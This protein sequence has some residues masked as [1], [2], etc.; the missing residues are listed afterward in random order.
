MTRTRPL[1]RGEV[2]LLR[3][4]VTPFDVQRM[5]WPS[6][7]DPADC[8]RW[9]AEVWAEPDF[10]TAVRA[11]TPRLVRAVEQAVDDPTRAPTKIRRAVTA[12]ARYLLR[13]TGRPTPFGLFAGMATA[14]CGPA[15]VRFG[16][17]HRPVAR[18][19]TL[20]LD[21][22]RRDLQSRS[23]VLPHLIVAADDLTV[24]RGSTLERPLPGGR[25]AT[26]RLTRP[27]AA[28]L[29]MAA[30]PVPYR[31]VVERLITMGGSAAQAAHLLATAVG[32]GL[33]T[34]QLQAP[35]TDMDPLGHL[36]HVL[37]PVT[38]QLEPETVDV[39]RELRDVHRLLGRHNTAWDQSTAREIRDQAERRM[40]AINDAGRVRLSVD[41]RLDATVQIPAPVLDE[42]EAAAH[43]LLRLTR[44]QGERPAWAAYHSVFW[45]RYGAGSLVPV[46]DAVDL[47]AGVGLPAGFATSL[48]PEPPTKALPR[49]EL[50]MRRAWQAAV[51][52]E[53]EI[54]L[55]DADIEEL[56]PTSHGGA[57]EAAIAPHVEM[58]VRVYAESQQDL[59]RGDFTVSVRPAW[60]TG[61]L[62][63]RF[64]AILRDGGLR[65]AYGKL[66]TLVDGALPAQLSFTPLYPH[67][68][69]V[70][71]TPAF[72]P[73]VIPLGEHRPPS[74][75]F[76]P[77]D[78]LAVLSTGKRL[79][80]VSLSRRRV[81]EP[82]VLH[83]LA[84]EKQAPPLVR[85]LAQLGRGF[86]TA[87]T[88]F[89]WGPLAA[90]MPFL[91]R[92]RYRKSLLTPA[93]WRL[94]ASDLPAGSFDRAWHE[95]LTDWAHAWRCPR[96]V[97]L[98]EGD[99]TL[100]LDL[101]V[102][103]HARLLFDHLRRHE[104]ADLY[105]AAGEENLGWIG[106]AHEIV[107][108]LTSTRPPLP[109]PN[110]Q[111]APVVTNRT[112]SDPGSDRPW[113]QAKL[114]T[115]PAAMDQILARALP[116]SLEQLDIW[117]VRYRSL[118]EE[119]HLRLRI[120]APDP[121]AH[122]TITQTIVSWARQLQDDALAS[123]LVFDGYRPETGRYGTGAAMSAAEEVFTADSS[124]VR[125]ALADLPR[126]DRRLLCVLGMV[127]IALGLLGEDDGT[128]WM[129]TNPAPGIGLPSVTRAV[130]QQTRAGLQTRPSGWT[131]RLDAAS[132]ARRNALHR[133][134]KHLADG[135]ITTVLESL[136]HMHHNRCIGPDRESEAACRHA[137]RQACRTVWI[138]RAD[139]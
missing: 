55:S 86:A 110:I 98:R 126:T 73:Y 64:A 78:D 39:L 3:A 101:R 109:A 18:P 115:A 95:A 127:D 13:A 105:E 29:E 7:D 108:P 32:A 122:A 37:E 106:H 88:Q 90:G 136:L 66:P 51:T 112:L 111:D 124:A 82:V 84:L 60:S 87:W 139:Q 123:R 92:V 132:T 58:G 30:V 79:H 33:V 62:T 80:L 61:N 47:A 93:R 74:A 54:R 45:D 12:T 63:G 26:V 118:L 116:D 77:L 2:L 67:A 94:A 130:A 102:A 89:D 138:R 71:R 48:W 21:H 1:Q 137:A 117:F 125:Y 99:R 40:T 119:N 59:D 96:S 70:A 5:R 11:A 100:R 91:P 113:V 134:R 104:S 46:R 16:V 129:A 22:V 68:E 35:I 83:P 34:T 57:V 121:A 65:E 25:T 10:A 9:L 15:M 43:A 75:D 120:A 97:E 31:Q 41:L 38:T 103:L 135:Q 23:D 131:P 56:S 17:E 49:D 24:R 69:N 50:L 20:W 53:Q 28:I 76:I 72:L 81:V 85:F 27:L 14:H 36:L 44:H 6:P 52:G 114:F 128:N 8:R 107:L 133:Y 4:A 42:A 19:D